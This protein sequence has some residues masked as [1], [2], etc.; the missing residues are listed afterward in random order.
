MTLKFNQ[1]SQ[2]TE[3]ELGYVYKI[4][5]AAV[6]VFASVI[7]HNRVSKEQ[8]NLISAY[9][10]SAP[11]RSFKYGDYVKKEKFISV[12]ELAKDLKIKTS[13]VRVILNQLATAG[14]L[15]ACSENLFSISYH[16]AQQLIY[17]KYKVRSLAHNLFSKKCSYTR[18]DVLSG[19]FNNV[20]TA[21]VINVEKIIKSESIEEMTFISLKNLS[22]LGINKDMVRMAIKPYNLKMVNLKKAVDLTQCDIEEE[23]LNFRGYK[24]MEVNFPTV[25]V[26]REWE[27]SF[28]L[29]IFDADI[30]DPECEAMHSYSRMEAGEHQISLYKNNFKEF[31]MLV[32]DMKLTATDHLNERWFDKNGKIRLTGRKAI[33]DSFIRLLTIKAQLKLD[34]ICGYDWLKTNAIRQF[35]G[36]YSSSVLKVHQLSKAFYYGLFK[37]NLA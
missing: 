30:T 4:T 2:S 22:S 16:K 10:M 9:I 11:V 8:K 14:I 6:R 32:S 23:L 15:K 33:A 1:L 24:E 35:N 31:L 28:A 27:E 13:F 29:E 25:I 21:S 3:P 20:Y 26:K 36:L 17:P 19:D 5:P 12:S 7:K 18:N 34:K 37:E